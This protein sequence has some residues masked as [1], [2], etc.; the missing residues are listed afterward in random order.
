MF[1]LRGLTKN[2]LEIFQIIIF[3]QI[4]GVSRKTTNL[5]ILLELG[6]YPISTRQKTFET[7]KTKTNIDLA[8]QTRLGN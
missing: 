3:K 1:F 6:R 8:P 5:S 2:K 4:L 7:I